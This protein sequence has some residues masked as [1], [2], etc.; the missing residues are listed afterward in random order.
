VQSSRPDS[1]PAF[2]SKKQHAPDLQTLRDKL[3]ASVWYHKTEALQ[4]LRD[5]ILAMP[6]TEEDDLA[7]TVRLSVEM[8]RKETMPK[9]IEEY[10]QFSEV[11]LTHLT[12]L[13]VN[14]DMLA[15]LVYIFLRHLSSPKEQI[16]QQANNLINLAQT[17]IGA[18]TLIVTMLEI[19]SFEKVIEEV[20]TIASALEVLNV[21]ILNCDSFDD[22]R[23]QICV[24]TLMNILQ[25][26][27]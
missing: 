16:K 6:D 8:F 3:K 13:I 12:H 4:M 15:D 18:S 10:L 23:I 7:V 2:P 20:M 24:E 17:E 22:T 25:I 5:A 11:L 9:V 14:E 26:H 27:Q 1:H 19:M 21:L